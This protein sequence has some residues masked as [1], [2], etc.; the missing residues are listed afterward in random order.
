M[1]F[2]NSNKLCSKLKWVPHLQQYNSNQ[3]ILMVKR[4]INHSNYTM[5]IQYITF[6]LIYLYMYMCN[7]IKY[8]VFNDL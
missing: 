5:Y 6:I 2:M 1:K 4:T 8:T 7:I 3:L